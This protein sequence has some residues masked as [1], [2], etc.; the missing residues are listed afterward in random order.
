M[1][2]LILF[3]FPILLLAQSKQ[4]LLN[5]L[6]REGAIDIVDTSPDSTYK[7]LIWDGD[8]FKLGSAQRVGATVFDTLT[9]NIFIIGT[10][11]PT[12]IQ[13][14]SALTCG[15]GAFDTTATTDTVLVTGALAT[16]LYLVTG[17]GGSVD[18]Q[19]ILQVEALADKF[20]V[21]RLASGAS[22]LAYNWF[23]FV[24]E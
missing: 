13:M 4:D 11:I 14:D 17:V 22:G 18:Q 10:L 19:D 5:N 12:S 6:Q 21:H 9:A 2:Y 24:H 15:V 8:E 23:R 7:F 3:L 1:K 16:D 20:V